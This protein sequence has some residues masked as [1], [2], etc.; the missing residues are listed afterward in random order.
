[1]QRT[2]VDSLGWALIHSLWQCAVIS[3]LFAALN[4][5]LHRA[6]ANARY[7]LG[8]VALLGMPLAAVATFLSLYQQHVLPNGRFVALAPS[9]PV[10]SRIASA[11]PSAAITQS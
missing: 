1:M 5:A 9:V 10:L 6:S 3:V 4:L 7:I 11:V 2:M 8:Y